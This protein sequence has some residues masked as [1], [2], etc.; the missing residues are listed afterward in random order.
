MPLTCLIAAHDPWFIQLLRIYSEESGFRVAQVYEGQEVL[1]MIYQEKPVAV[2]L[3]ADLPG[4]IKGWEVLQSIMADPFACQVPVLVFS[5]LTQLNSEDVPNSMMEGAAAHLQEP[6]TFEIFQDA[7]I[8]VGVG[9]L[10]GP[11]AFETPPPGDS[12]SK[13]SHSSNGKCC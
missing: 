5:W 8:K 10:A 1:P 11:K 4:K 6:V 13:H 12:A 9:G 2:F 7:L 3:Q